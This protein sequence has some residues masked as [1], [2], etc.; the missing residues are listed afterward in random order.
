[1]DFRR[2]DYDYDDAAARFIAGGSPVADR[3]AER[4]LDPPPAATAVERWG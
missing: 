4:V 2:S 3:F 1:V